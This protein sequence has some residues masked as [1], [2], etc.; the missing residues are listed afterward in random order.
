MRRFQLPFNALCALAIVSVAVAATPIGTPPAD[1]LVPTAS[2][3]ES[4][5]T[6]KRFNPKCEP[7]TLICPV[8]FMVLQNGHCECRCLNLPHD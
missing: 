1:K 3:G 7:C 2:G 5:T 4:P 6:V 8:G